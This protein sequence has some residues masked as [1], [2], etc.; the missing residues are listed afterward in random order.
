MRVSVVA[1]W[2][3]KRRHVHDAV[4]D[5]LEHG[6]VLSR[7]AGVR[8]R[9]YRECATRKNGILLEQC[10]HDVQGRLIAGDGQVQ[11]GRLFAGTTEQTQNGD[12]AGTLLGHEPVVEEARRSTRVSGARLNRQ[13]NVELLRPILWSDDVKFSA[14][15]GSARQ[16]ECGEGNHCGVRHLRTGCVKCS[17]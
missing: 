7:L 1:S 8:R 16:E 5:G 4:Q 2:R 9:V 13:P 17:R 11:H 10:R 3:T 6:E 15:T 14:A 12:D